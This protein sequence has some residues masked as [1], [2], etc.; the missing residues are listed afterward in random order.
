MNRPQRAH[1]ER[2]GDCTGAGAYAG[3]T[4]GAQYH[5]G[6][7]QPA[8]VLLMAEVLI[9]GQRDIESVA[10]ATGGCVCSL[11]ASVASSIRS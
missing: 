4:G 6:E 7:T 8:D 3:P 2:L 5:D 11:T 1:G 10:L 9:G